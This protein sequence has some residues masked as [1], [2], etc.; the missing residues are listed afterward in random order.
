MDWSWSPQQLVRIKASLFLFWNQE[1]GQLQ[2]DLRDAQ[3]LADRTNLVADHDT[4]RDM[5]WD[6]KH[7]VTSE[8]NKSFR[9]MAN[10]VS[11]LSATS[12]ILKQ[13]PRHQVGIMKDPATGD[14]TSSSG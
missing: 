14:Y 8:K 2:S 6:M 11:S 10:S 7:L 3:K 13:N 12:K 9:K 4:H 5:R 1:L